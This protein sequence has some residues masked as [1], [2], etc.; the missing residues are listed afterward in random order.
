[1]TLNRLVR[2]AGGDL[3]FLQYLPLVIGKE[4]GA[5][6]EPL[7]FGGF[8]R[9]PTAAAD[10]YIDGEVGVFPIFKL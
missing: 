5:D 7:A 1:M 2:G 6:E 9:E 4:S 8:K 3:A 10:D